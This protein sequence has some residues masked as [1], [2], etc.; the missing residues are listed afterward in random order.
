MNDMNAQQ[1]TLDGLAPRKRKR[2]APAQRKVAAENPIAQV[3]L[4]VQ[5]THLGRSF[6]YL[7]EERFSETAQPGVMVRVRFGGRLVDGIVWGRVAASDTPRSALRFIER[8]AS[9][10]VLVSAAM[11]DDVTRIAE[12]YGGTRANILRLAVP[13]RVARVDDEQ[14]FAARGRWIG[15]HG[16]PAI[17]Q[18]SLEQ[19]FAAIQRA[20]DGSAALRAG[21]EG[22]AFAAFV[23][24]ARPG[25][26]VWADD[27][28]WMIA[29]AIAAGKP[30]AVVLPG[31]RQCDDLASALQRYGLRRFAPDGSSR[32]GYSGDFVVLAA[33][34]PP[35][36]R[37][38][39]Y[40]AAA[41]GQV[42]CVIGLRA[43]MY[44]PIES[45]GLFMV[46]DDAAYQQADG[47][48]P[49]AQA[50]GVMRLRAE[51]HHG[52][53][54]ALSFARSALSQ[55]E[56][57]DET[58]V[59]PVS[60]PSMAMS[61]LPT[62]RRDDMPWIR[63]LNR[64]EL[65]RLADPSIGARVPHTA[66]A[67]LSAALQT[68]PV[69][70]S[71][72]ADGISEAL[73]CAACHAQARCAKCTG[74][75][76]RV[77]DGVP[78][79]RW[80]AAAAVGWTCPHCGGERMRVVRVG[81][82][83]TARELAGLFRGVPVVMS[84]PSQPRGIVEFVDDS[85]RIVI[86][87]PGAEPRV[88]ATRAART[89]RAQ[90]EPAGPAPGRSPAHEPDAGERT[91][92]MP[93][94]GEYRAVAILDA[95]TSLYAPGVD[96]R[97]DTLTAWMRAMSLCAPRSR[98]GQGLIL[99]E[100]DRYVAQALM[101]WDSSSLAAR[102]LAERRE[103]GMPP[104]CSVACV[105]GRRDAV[106]AALD[107]IGVLHGDWAE[108]QID[109]EPMPGLLGPVPIPPPVTVSARELESTA[110]RVKALVRVPVKRRAELARRLQTTVAR[111]V[112]SRHPGELRFQVDPKDLI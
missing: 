95:W 42:G 101:L 63:W 35:A 27:A 11:R 22:R 106:M 33:G 98:G 30:C 32:G 94:R 92:D 47:M 109:G 48:M 90:P 61:L 24:D 80:C 72:P 102:E 89:S 83:G 58:T 99:G 20:Y 104:I 88:I 19:G 73:S 57:G 53:F 34:L 76:E 103:T 1:L 93:E 71:I 18:H 41:T 12:A 67:T 87:T 2:R 16:T 43:A 75:L 105:W 70:L 23:M 49:Y 10:H 79:C 37:Y 108:L 9:P 8:V 36:E 52:V 84:S 14:R 78:R 6:D 54:V 91:A 7:V 62:A 112:A 51:S 68:G 111:H 26:A 4:D 97:A 85:P 50:R 86:A 60:G 65:A 56:T 38:R 46:V 40:L 28:A 3:V 59:T 55:W 74:P 17:R 107:E 15:S 64:E 82:A 13:P 45:A 100:C 81:A 29:D 44:A 69:L 31:M 21:I 66:V 110:D 5:A 39:A 96:A 25:A 77:G